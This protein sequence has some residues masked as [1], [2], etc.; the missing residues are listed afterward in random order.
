MLSWLLCKCIYTYIKK[1]ISFVKKN[2]NNEDNMHGIHSPRMA[3]S[4]TEILE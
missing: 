2:L 3:N 4:K 1:E